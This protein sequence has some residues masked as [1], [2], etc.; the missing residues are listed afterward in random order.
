MVSLAALSIIALV[1]II[2]IGILKPNVNIG[3]LAIAMA[4]IIGGLVANY[5][6]KS[7]SALFP[8][9]LFL[10]LVGITLLFGIASANNTLD[11]IAKLLISLSKGNPAIL[12]I[13]FFFLT[14]ILSAIG[15]GNIASVALI[16]PVG[17]AIASKAKINPLLMAIMI[18]TGANAGA[19]SPISPTGIVGIGLMN[20]IGII[21]LQIPIIIFL[22]AAG[23]QT[24]TAFAAYAIFGGYKAKPTP[25]L[26]E[27]LESQKSEKFNNKQIL[28]F[29]TIILLVIGIIFAKISIIIAS[30]TLSGI[31]LLLNTVDPE[32]AIKK[33][34]WDAILLVTGVTILIGIMEKSG[35]LD[36]A[37]D[38]IVLIASPNNIN[39]VLAFITGI[40][41]AYSSSS[42][43]VMPTFIPLVP[44]IIEKLGGGNLVEML[45]AVSVGSHMVDVSPLSTLGAICIACLSPEENKNKLFKNLMLWGLSMAFV[46]AGLSYLFLD[47]LGSTLF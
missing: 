25:Q 32:K 43:V 34:P 24:I 30:F 13:T 8:S 16:A 33:I 22:A 41:S 7:I 4:F 37:T 14:F 44:G 20:K 18:C 26:I 23:I 17:M 6:E 10:M 19:F 45:I 9:N 11:K 3:I 39:S 28:T 47:I 36:L 2:G 46:G 27:F 42:G 12:P 15:P 5:P 40:I 38:W 29:V 1:L 31:L 21:G 35:G